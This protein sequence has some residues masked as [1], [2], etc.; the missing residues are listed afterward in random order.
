MNFEEYQKESRKTAMYKPVGKLN[1]IYPVLGL[2]DEAGE[3]LGKFKKVIRDENQVLTKEK[4]E[5]IK[6]ELGDVLWYLAQ[7]STDLG[8]SLEDVAKSNINK[9]FSRKERGKIQGSGDNR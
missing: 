1:Y 9:L 7:I 5:E 6:F 8:L 3:V 4:I 2:A